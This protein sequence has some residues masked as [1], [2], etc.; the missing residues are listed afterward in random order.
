MKSK[1]KKEKEKNKD[2]INFIDNLEDFINDGKVSII[3]E[4]KKYQTLKDAN[5]KIQGGLAGFQANSIKNYLSNV[6]LENTIEFTVSGGVDRFLYSNKNIRYMSSK[7]DYAYINKNCNLSNDKID[8]WLKPKIVIAGMTKVIEAV[9]TD[10]PLGLGVGIYGIQG[11]TDFEGYVL[12]AILNSKFITRY[13]SEKFKD[14]ALAGG[15]LALNKNTIEEIPYIKPNKDVETKLYTL[16][17]EIHKIKKDN[18]N[19]D[20]TTLERE[21][22][23]LVY[24]L[25]NLTNEE[26]AIVEN[27]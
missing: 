22:D 21:I 24:Q 11:I 20:T 16:S 6:K 23:T 3:K 13:F 8:F 26:I 27:S 1:N 4:L 12:T 15:Y 10:Q 5:F 9:Y 14:K 19:A 18:P 7:Y 17:T 25:Y 2:K